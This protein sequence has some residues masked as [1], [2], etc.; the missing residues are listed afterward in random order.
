MC[1]KP[2][3]PL[4]LD[5]VKTALDGCFRPNDSYRL[6]HRLLPVHSE[7]AGIKALVSEPPEPRIRALK[8]FFGSISMGDDLLIFGIH[9]ANET[10][11][12]VEVGGV[13]NEILVL[14][15]IKA[16]LRGSLKPVILDLLEFKRAVAGKL[17]ELP[18][19][20]AFFDPEL[21]PFSFITFFDIRLLPK[22]TFATVFAPESLL[23]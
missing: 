19:A 14:G 11:I 8:A 15:V 6:H 10:P 21:E 13:I 4:T 9:E 2:S 20:I 7:K 12:F 1:S 22:E 18:D 16:L 23:F 17:A 3:H 5:V